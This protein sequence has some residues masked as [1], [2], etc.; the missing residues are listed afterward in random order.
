MHGA[1]D[2]RSRKTT[3]VRLRPAALEHDMNDFIT[4]TQLAA[5][6]QADLDAKARVDDDDSDDEEP[7]THAEWRAFNDEARRTGN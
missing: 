6:H 3:P 5:L 1:I 4:P 7:M 2:R